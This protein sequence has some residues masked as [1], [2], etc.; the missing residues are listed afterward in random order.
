MISSV[1]CNLSLSSPAALNI[2][3]LQSYGLETLLTHLRMA[4]DASRYIHDPEF[5][6]Q[7]GFF[8]GWQGEDSSVSADPLPHTARKLHDWL[9]AACSADCPMPCLFQLGG[10]L[11]K[12]RV[13]ASLLDWA[14]RCP[15]FSGAA[16]SAAPCTLCNIWDAQVSSDAFPQP[17]LPAVCCLL[18]AAW[19]LLSRLQWHGR[20]RSAVHAV[21]HLGCTGE[22]RHPCTAAAVCCLPSAACR[23]LPAACRLPSAVCYSCCQQLIEHAL[24]RSRARGRYLYTQPHQ[25]SSRQIVLRLS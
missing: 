10:A 21:R 1:A 13:Q 20:Q 22:L 5:R 18:P 23:L 24:C 9:A 11:R 8:P 12:P 2:T 14:A 17:L 19:R 3:S 7:P 16:S 4:P 25:S 6:A 15:G